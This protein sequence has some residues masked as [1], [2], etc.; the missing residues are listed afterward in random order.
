[1]EVARRTFSGSFQIDFNG[2]GAYEYILSGDSYF[3]ATGTTTDTSKFATSLI[4][5]A[6]GYGP[7]LSASFDP[8]WYWVNTR[9][10]GDAITITSGRM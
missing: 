3:S 5:G 8:T 1:M 2:T 4:S 9:P 10:T 7:E 6:V